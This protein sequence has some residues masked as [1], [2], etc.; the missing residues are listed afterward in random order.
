MKIVYIASIR[1]PTEKAHGVQIMKTCEAM[2]KM[3]IDI[4]L[5]VP[6][7]F[8]SSRN[9]D[10]FEYYGIKKSFTIRRFFSVRLIRLGPIGFAIETFLF[11][12]SVLF[13]SDYWSADYIFSR[14]ESLVA[15]SSFIGKKTIWETHTG[16]NNFLARIALERSK[17]IVAISQGLK[18]FY[19]SNKVLSSKIVVAHDGVDLEDFGHSVNKREMRKIL[20][21]PMEKKIVMYAGRLDGWKGTETFISAI[22]LWESKGMSDVLGVVIGGSER[23]VIELS[24]K[25]PTTRFVRHVPY[26][27][28][29]NYLKLSDVLVIP[30]TAKNEISKLFTSPLK[31]F[32]YMAT[33]VPIVASNLPS[34]REILNENNAVLVLPDDVNSLIEGIRSI[35]DDN[36]KAD[37]IAKQALHDVAKYSWN[38]RVKAIVSSL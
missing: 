26:K 19:L 24:R 20:G 10:P 8:L 14:D 9:T 38:E 12:L 22:K 31:V 27:E 21:F 29:A 4:S 15:F 32:A 25:W 18:D 35:L 16:S 3:G 36:K 34:I 37:I 5:F 6:F 30:N 23:E 28:L 13:S 1:L 7:F 2:S 17:L 33:G 11:F